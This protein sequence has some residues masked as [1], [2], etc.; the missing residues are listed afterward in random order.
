MCKFSNTETASFCHQM[1][2]IIKSGISSTEGLA[3]LSADCDSQEEKD[4]LSRMISCINETASLARAAEESGLFPDYA[5]KMMLIGEETGRLDDVLESLSSH[6]SR[7]E[8]VSNTIRS[9]A[10]FPLLMLGMM[11]VVV[12][13]LLIKVLPVFGQVFNNLGSE[14]TG[15]SGVLLGIVNV[16]STHPAPFVILAI[17]IVAALIFMIKTPGAG[18]F[19]VKAAGSFGPVRKLKTMISTC[20]FASALALTISSGIYPQRGLELVYDL[21]DDEEFKGKVDAVRKQLEQGCDLAAALVDCHIFTGLHA[22][23]LLI[24]QRTGKLDQALS[25]V[26]DSCQEEIDA[27]TD[28][29]LSYIEPAIVAVFSVLA[30]IIL[31]SVMFPLMG[32]M[33]GL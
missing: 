2:V 3:L 28:K 13:V 31:L 8:E 18:R 22:R 7:Q 6:Y 1:A 10:S 12:L 30:G 24:G 29:L 16:I 20:S 17:A 19:F 25:K 33:S 15:I 9:A 5:V 11:L 23:T 27:R 4:I 14:M 21:T 32:I 26:A